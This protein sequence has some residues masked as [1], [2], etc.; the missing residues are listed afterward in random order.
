MKIQVILLLV[1][2]CLGQSV[3]VEEEYDDFVDCTDPN[4]IDCN[5]THPEICTECRD[6]YYLFPDNAT[7]QLCSGN[8]S[9]CELCNYDTSVKCSSC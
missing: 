3:Y 7:C 8:I 6:K 5:I 4:C 1:L 2:L 9:H